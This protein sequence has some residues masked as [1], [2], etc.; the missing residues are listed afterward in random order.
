MLVG[1][2]ERGLVIDPEHLDPIL[3][4]YENANVN[5]KLEN[6]TLRKDL[7]N[8]ADTV[9]LLLKDNQRLREF[10]D[11]KNA[12]I[13]G[14][15]QTVCEN[16]GELVISLKSNIELLT[17]ENKQLSYEL[18]MLKELRMKDRNKH[19]MM[20][21]KM[22]EEKRIMRR[23]A[24]D[25]SE[26]Q[27]KNQS[28]EHQIRILTSKVDSLT[29][30]LE[31]ETEK[32]ENL[33]R[34][35]LQVQV[36]PFHDVS[37]INRPTSEW[38]TKMNSLKNFDSISQSN[39]ML[40]EENQ[41]LKADIQRI[42]DQT[43]K[44]EG[45]I[46]SLKRTVEELEKDLESSRGE[47]IS[48]EHNYKAM[49]KKLDIL[50]EDPRDLEEDSSP[51]EASRRGGEDR[52]GI[53]SQEARVLKEEVTRLKAML[54]DKDRMSR[55]QMDQITAVN[56]DYVQ[57]LTRENQELKGDKRNLLL[58]VRALVEK[59]K[60]PENVPNVEIQANGAANDQAEA[61]LRD[62]RYLRDMNQELERL[63]KEYYDKII[64]LSNRPQE[65]LVDP[66]DHTIENH[67]IG[68][69]HKRTSTKASLPRDLGRVRELSPFEEI[70]EQI[71]AKDMERGRSRSPHSAIGGG[72]HG[73]MDDSLVPI[74]PLIDRKK[75]SSMQPVFRDS[76]RTS[77]NRVKPQTSRSPDNGLAA[78]GRQ[79][80]TRGGRPSNQII[81]RGSERNQQN[82]GTN[83]A[84][85]VQNMFEPP[86]QAQQPHLVLTDTSSSNLRN[87]FS[88]VSQGPFNFGNN[89]LSLDQQSG[90]HNIHPGILGAFR[91]NLR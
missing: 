87:E 50:I 37:N 17:N 59:M 33:D 51:F 38:E 8:L 84:H 29:E 2:D 47:V 9:E 23:N 68:Q 41:N 78:Q 12:D 11:Q 5:L 22:I 35:L 25:L 90:P 75:K 58:K 14:V 91:T 60:R 67:R 46:T 4:A 62:N 73:S 71:N 1:I 21:D 56:E 42:K 81:T 36:K 7:T 74:D 80:Q 48:M 86:Q 19:E 79:S 88:T 85:L 45:E 16:E 53:Q 27:I 70:A 40:T 30:E 72:Y 49:K 3:N 57:T 15:L 10:L 76:A 28:L 54:G 31:R 52:I 13:E 83:M 6:N 82:N 63:N 39:A 61:L 77:M 69:P 24:E 44:K 26:A 20:D 32:R 64:M 43:S 66:T 55:L 65:V 89:Q 34:K 18:S